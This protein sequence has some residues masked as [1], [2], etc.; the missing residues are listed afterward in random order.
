MRF[1][2]WNNLFGQSNF[3]LLEV[4]KVNKLAQLY[5]QVEFSHPKHV[6]ATINCPLT[7]QPIVEPVISIEGVIYEKAAIN[8]RILLFDDVPGS[9][10]ALTT[11]DLTSFD[12]LIGVLQYSKIRIA[13]YF[14]A[15][16]QLIKSAQIAVGSKET[17]LNYH[18]IFICPLSKRLIDKAVI[19]PQGRVYDFEAIKGFLET[20]G[21]K[22]DPIDGSP[23]SLETL[24]PFRSF[25]DNLAL[26]QNPIADSK[27]QANQ[28]VDNSLKAFGTGASFIGSLFSAAPLIEDKGQL[29][30]KPSMSFQL[31]K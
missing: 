12:A 3:E 16:S 22:H 15:E 4:L 10:L 27:F 14:K 19:T 5:R 11:F 31:R 23:L 25:S 30:P 24:E 21:Q 8:Q 17:P 9:D 1:W 7:N 26:Y 2:H 18:K 6:N 28:F 13:D 29:I 20:T